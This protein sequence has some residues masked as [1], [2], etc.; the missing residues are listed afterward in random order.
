MPNKNKVRINVRSKQI[1]N[2]EIRFEKRANGRDVIVVPS[3]TL[4]DDVI[5]NGVLYPAAEIASSFNSLERSMAPLGH[6]VIN[7]EHVS[8]SDPE[9]INNHYVGAWNENVRQKDGVVLLDKVIDVEI[10]NSTDKGKSLLA[11]INAGD[12]INT[13]T[14]L[15][16]LMENTAGEGYTKI[17][18]SMMFDH[19]AILL[20]EDGAAT[21]AQG[22][23]MMVNSDD[24]I[25]VI[26]SS[27][28]EDS[29]Q[30]IDWA[31]D[32]LAEAIERKKRLPALETIKTAL[33]EAL[34]LGRET[35]VNQGDDDMSKEEIAA[36]DVK[37]DALADSIGAIG[38]TIGNAMSLALKP[39]ID[40]QVIAN[41]ATKTAEVA[42][43]LVLVNRLVTG[44]VLTNEVAEAMPVEALEVLANKMVPLKAAPLNGTSQ[45]NAAADA[46]AFKLPQSEVK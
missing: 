6:P 4:P 34:G 12:P 24:K 26:N 2:S 16:A 40:A 45:V 21:P 41:A 15:F 18:R 29:D 38:E 35:S 7:G 46:D 43:K 23:G 33:I 19:D 8:A 20:N 28:E 30:Q 1:V 36:L 22:V 14:G 32:H 25:L 3:A 42:A 31:L 13:S 11:A 5:M 37:V 44:Q 9:A 17:A 10:A 27:L 39:L